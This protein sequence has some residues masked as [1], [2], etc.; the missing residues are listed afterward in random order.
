MKRAEDFREAFG[1]AERGFEAAVRDTLEEMQAK[2]NHHGAFRGRRFLVPVI[3]ALLIMILG[4]GIAAT[5][6]WGVLNW[7]A[8]NRPEGADST[9]LPFAEETAEPFLAQADTDLVTITVRE[10][11]TDGYGIYLSVAF[12]PKEKD[13]LALNWSVNP[14]Q[15]GP[16]AVGFTPDE[17]QKATD[18]IWVD[19]CKLPERQD[20]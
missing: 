3:A 19:V 10:A 5:G 9:E 18:G 12:T 11:K 15:S 6:R 2:E 7:L 13:T 17:L 1:P 4:I 14:S 16:E 8:E 20:P